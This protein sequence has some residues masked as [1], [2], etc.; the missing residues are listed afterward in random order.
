MEITLSHKRSQ[1]SVESRWAALLDLVVLGQTDQEIGQQL[2][3][4][5]AAV[6]RVILVLRDRF[7]QPN[8]V[9]LAV[10]WDR[11]NRGS[12]QAALGGEQYFRH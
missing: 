9:A 3:M 10:W 5:R 6:S 1:H 2:E 7:K 4:T 12:S 11:Q 8:R